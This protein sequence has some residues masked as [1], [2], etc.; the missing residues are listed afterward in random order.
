MPHPQIQ[1]LQNDSVQLESFAQKLES[2]GKYD[3]VKKIKAKKE[4]LDEYITKK[5]IMPG[6]RAA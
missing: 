1:R 2:E 5:S 3:L 4:F 6:V